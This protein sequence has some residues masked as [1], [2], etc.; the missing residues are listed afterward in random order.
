MHGATGLGRFIWKQRL[1][2][3][4]V[5]NLKVTTRVADQGQQVGPK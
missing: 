4:N 2:D 5:I 1:F 3:V